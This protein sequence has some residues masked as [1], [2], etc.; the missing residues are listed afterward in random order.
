VPS[1]TNEVKIGISDIKTNMTYLEPLATDGFNH[2]INFDGFLT[3]NT[4]KDT[5]ECYSYCQTF[6]SGLIEAIRVYDLDESKDNKYFTIVGEEKEVILS[7]LRYFKALAQFKIQGLV[8]VCISVM[9][10][11][12]VN[13]FREQINTWNKAT[14]IDR[15]VL[16]L[17]EIPIEDYSIYSDFKSLAREFRHAFNS[18]WNAG[19][20]A[21]S[22]NYDEKGDFKG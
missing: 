7:T 1:F 22:P 6:T 15:D 2:R 21:G 18:V 3:Y 11:K 5:K 9:G 16:L 4:Y 12:G 8:W 20:F 13:L 19:G 17:P 14:P 10:A